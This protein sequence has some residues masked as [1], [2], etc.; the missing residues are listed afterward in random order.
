M[1][2]RALPLLLLVACGARTDLGGQR[3][4][5]SAPATQS[6]GVVVN[7][8]APNDGPQVTFVLPL[9]GATL[10]A[11]PSSL[12]GQ[13]GFHISFWNPPPS[14]PGTYAIGDG[15]FASGSSATYCPLPPGPCTT[16]DHGTFTLT[17]LTSEASG[18]FTVVLPDNTSMSGYFS[19]IPVCHNKTLCG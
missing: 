15:S 1:R 16:A 7:E 4:D 5:A 19:K 8:C 10:P 9:E 12:G 6:P 17:E 13:G 14:A 11:C 3:E 18:H 2:H